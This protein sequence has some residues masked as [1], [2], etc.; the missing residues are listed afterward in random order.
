MKIQDGRGRGLWASVSA[1]FRLNV[2]AKSN[3]RTF[4]IS[5]DDGRSYSLNSVVTSAVA[6]NIVAYLKNTSST[7]NLYVKQIHGSSLNAAMFKAWIVTG[8][9]SGTTI[10]PTN[11]NLGSGLA[12]EATAAGDAVVT[13]LT[14]GNLVET[15]RVSASS[16]DA[17][18]LEDALILTPDT[19]IGVEYDTGTSGPCEINITFHY[20]EI[21]R[22]N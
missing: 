7:R 3:P 10:T 16:H 14:L 13:N 21:L 1:A 4:Y 6:G 17:M 12:A 20:E 11:L 5:R 2:S 18:E 9:S 22:L 19:A 15:T 8:T